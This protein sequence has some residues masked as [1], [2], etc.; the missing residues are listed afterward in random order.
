MAA[1]RPY[2]SSSIASLAREGGWS[3]IRKDLGVRSFGVNAWTIQRSG[4]AAH[5]AA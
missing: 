5:P 4:P 3:P 1:D 2:E